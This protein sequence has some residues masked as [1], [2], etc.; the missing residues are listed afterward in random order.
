MGRRPTDSG[1]TGRYERGKAK[2]ADAYYRQRLAEKELKEI[3][4][5]LTEAVEAAQKWEARAKVA[6]AQ[7]E[8]WEAIAKR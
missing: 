4:Q 6:E 3:R 1:V 7:N 2:A 5:K 8:A